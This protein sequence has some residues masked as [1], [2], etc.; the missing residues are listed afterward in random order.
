MLMM[1]K[2][3]TRSQWRRECVDQAARKKRVGY[4]IIGKRRDELE[5]GCCGL[6]RF[7]DPKPVLPTL[8]LSDA[9]RDAAKYRVELVRSVSRAC[10]EK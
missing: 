4:W 2:R 7:G 10:H 5:L 6:F 3:R 1:D 9:C 8:L